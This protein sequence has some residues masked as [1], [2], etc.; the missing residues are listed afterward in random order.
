MPEPY[1]SGD[2]IDL[3]HGDC[4]EET[5]WLDADVLVTDPPYGVGY[6]AK[7][8]GTGRQSK[9]RTPVP[10]AND[11][12]F[13]AAAAAL[14][15]WGAR[16][17]ACFANHASLFRTLSTVR[18]VLD[19]VRVMTWHK[20]NINGATPGNP[21]MA[22][23]EFAVCGVVEWPRVARSGL[24]SA[25][26]FTG[27]PEWNSSPDAYLHPTQK[28]VPVMEAVIHAMPVGTIADPFA[29]SG[30]TLVAAKLQGR[31]AIGVELE[32]RYCEIAARRLDQGVLDFGD[33]S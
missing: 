22:D 27:N 31:R 15:N 21:W 29:G 11:H 2:G 19:R 26:R 9:G 12:D 20:T 33:A 3:Y 18:S 32:E 17:V 7:R 30:S 8:G 13:A 5:A 10:V 4:R 16:P 14:A 28:P 24:V 6:A 25:R 1:W 23:V